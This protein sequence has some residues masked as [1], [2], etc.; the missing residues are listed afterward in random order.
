MDEKTE[1]L[2]DIFMDVAEEETVTESQTEQRGSL[3]KEGSVDDRL[4]EVIERM[5]E[6]FDFSTD[7]DNEALC[8]VIRRFY[9]G[10]HDADIAEALSV[11]E[12]AVIEARLDLHLVREADT[13]GID[14]ETLRDCDTDTSVAAVA[15][16]LDADADTVSRARDALAAEERSRRASQRFR[17]EFEEVLTDADIAVRLT[18]DVQNDGL[19]EA[20]EGMEVDVE[21]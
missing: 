2:R 21:F 15:A 17:T 8:Q 3:L 14:V 11:S 16:E 7:L 10:Q 4:V 18:A 9:D 13:A 20:T 19:D 6:K 5:R 1:E 12:D